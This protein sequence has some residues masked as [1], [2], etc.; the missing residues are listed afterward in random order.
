MQSLAQSEQRGPLSRLRF[1]GRSGDTFGTGREAALGRSGL[2][3]GARSTAFPDDHAGVAQGTYLCAR[4]YS[5]SAL[6]NGLKS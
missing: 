5:T 3:A 1:E 4:A 6:V 2:E